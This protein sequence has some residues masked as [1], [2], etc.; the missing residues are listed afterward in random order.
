MQ[1]RGPAWLPG[2]GLVAM[3]LVAYGSAWLAGFVWDDDDYVTANVTLRSLDGLRRI[4]LEPG[5]VPQYYPLTFTTLWIEHAVWGLWPAG[6]HGTNVLLHA[7]CAV[8]AWRILRLLEVPG[9]WLGAALFAVHPVHVE[10]VVWIT[11]RKNVLSGALGL[12][13]AL[14]WLQQALAPPGRAPSRDVWI[15]T[16]LFVAALLAKAV[17]ATLPVVLLVLVWWRRGRIE[18]RDVVSLAPWF[19][20]AVASGL[21]TTWMEQT[22]VGA[23]G[24]AWEST[25]VER[26][27]IAGRAL[28]F[29]VAS[30]A[31]PTTLTFIYPRW[32]V[33]ASVWWQ[34]LFPMAALA[35]AVALWSARRRVGMGP[36]VAAVVFAVTLGPALGFVAVYPHRYSFVADHFQYLASLAPLALAASL[37]VRLDRAVMPVGGVLLAVLGLL[38]WRQGL[39]YRDAETLWLDTIAKNP[40]AEMAFVNL[41]ILQQES[42]RLDDALASYDRALALDPAAADVHRNRGNALAAQGRVDAAL[43]S[44]ATALRLDPS[45]ART[46]N[47]RA[48]TL[49]GAGRHGEAIVEYEGALAIDPR[50]ADA[51]G[52]LAN[53]LVMEGRRD[54][55]RAHYEQALAADPGYAEAQRNFAI[56]LANEGR[57]PE[58]AARFA[59]AVRLRPGWAEAQHDLGNALA[60]LGRFA[61]AIAPYRQ[62]LRLDPGYVDAHNNLGVAMANLG[63]RDEALMH[64]R[65]AL[66]LDPANAAAAANVGLLT[67]TP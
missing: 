56:L 24:A 37:L 1:A 20:V 58:A 47:S 28:W 11:E 65:E 45:D 57:L 63:R 43:E 39:A 52:N 32:V 44:F 27:L 15:A 25:F 66:R 14:L 16:A 31:W 40:S 3:V 5:A 46:R 38:T 60:A 54:E 4:W 61:D 13:A 10:S 17:V 26:V 9:A 42:G 41:G 29:Y 19:A 36:F 8:L 53:V 50:Y 35:A 59:E 64:F 55:A 34:W 6:Y 48:N 21:M 7:T 22:H 30:L 2:A 12:G 33:D 23:R 49:A 67:G 62:A 18:R 51:H